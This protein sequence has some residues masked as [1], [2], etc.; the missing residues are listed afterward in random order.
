MGPPLSEF[1]SSVPPS[2]RGYR[3]GSLLRH[4]HEIS[5]F[6][7][8]LED[9]NARWVK[10]V[11]FIYSFI[12][13]P[14]CATM[15]TIRVICCDNDNF[16]VITWLFS[17]SIWVAGWILSSTEEPNRR[18]SGLRSQTN[19]LT[20]VTTSLDLRALPQH[21]SRMMWVTS[22]KFLM[23]WIMRKKKLKSHF[24]K[25][26]VKYVGKEAHGAETWCPSVPP[27]LELILNEAAAA[28]TWFSFSTLGNLQSSCSAIPDSGVSVGNYGYG[29]GLHGKEAGSDLARQST[30]PITRR[31]NCLLTFTSLDYG[32]RCVLSWVGTP[33]SGLSVW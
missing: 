1:W 18:S 14:V 7:S 30:A 32:F 33:G 27:H 24:L 22:F 12:C 4:H 3:L 28:F 5:H 31:M 6:K 21:N 29:K 13:G 11:D 9:Q 17:V 25:I 23:L 2:Y 8:F 10:S 20:T 15:W 16:F 19:T 26:N